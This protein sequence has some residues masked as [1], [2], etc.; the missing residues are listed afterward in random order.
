MILGYV[1]Q[2]LH[3]L[4]SLKSVWKSLSGHP[5]GTVWGGEGG[6]EGGREG[7]G[8]EIGGGGREVGREGGREG[9]WQGRSEEENNKH[10]LPSIA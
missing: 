8:R 9:E 6:R 4:N 10:T 1:S 2:K 7:G 3:T 5:L